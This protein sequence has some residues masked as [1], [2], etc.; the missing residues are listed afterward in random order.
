VHPPSASLLGRL[1]AAALVLSSIAC[2]ALGLDP[3]ADKRG[4]LGRHAQLWARAG[5]QTY[6]YTYLPPCDACIAAVPVVVDVQN[7]TVASAH[8]ASDDPMPF[9][10]LAGIFTVEELFEIIDRAIDDHADALDVSYDPVLGYP[11]RIAIDRWF[12]AAGDEFSY[13]VGGLQSTT[14]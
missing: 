8:Y 7:G 3:A 10:D 14:D 5:I 9:L 4:D 1:L 11:S 12:E 6:R 2:S 13:Q